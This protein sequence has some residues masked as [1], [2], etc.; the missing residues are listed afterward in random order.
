M[1]RT[2][3]GVALVT[4]IL[5]VALAT[6]AAVAMATRQQ[7]DIRRTGN[8]LH[9]EQAWA[10]VLGA[11]SW[12]R[13]V[14]ARDLRESQRDSLDEDW[15]TQVPAALVEGGSVAGRLVD[16]QGR[17]NINSL[18]SQGRAVP[19]A[20][21]RFKRL[22]QVLEIS[23]TLAEALVDWLD[24]DINA[25][26]PDGAEDNAYL[27]V[28][29]AYRTANRPM[30][31]VSELRLVQG[32]TAEVVDKLLPFVCAL[33]S[34]SAA[35]NVNTAPPEVLRTLA[36]GLSEADGE[37]L[38]AARDQNPFDDVA[39]FLAEAP[40]AGKQVDPDSVS[41]SSQ[42]FRL[43]AA[44]DVGQGHAEL[45]SLIQRSRRQ[46]AVVRRE[47]LLREPVQVVAPQDQN[48]D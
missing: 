19:A 45:T 39:K 30:A 26:F 18:V 1:R 41:V 11:E 7:L 3:R 44:S 48:G 24:E 43:L 27:L 6:V 13:V 35:V 15:A 17:F 9:S 40:L 38:A 32:F 12:A 33:P 25:G 20:V 42:W 10:Y 21:D 23:E 46:T 16:L 8:L 36:A 28:Q 31:S 22:L 5:M 37:A 4:A 47:R 2:Q 29:P 34:S 14:L